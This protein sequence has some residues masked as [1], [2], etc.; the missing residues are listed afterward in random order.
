MSLTFLVPNRCSWYA[1]YHPLGVPWLTS[2][3]QHGRLDRPKACPIRFTDSRCLGSLRNASTDCF[4]WDLLSAPLP[5]IALAGQPPWRFFR[6][7]P[8]GLVESALGRFALDD[9]LTMTE[10][11][12]GGNWIVAGFYR[13]LAVA[14]ENW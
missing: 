7:E 5:L 11:C 3:L 14:L 1:F 12:L 8:L 6:G 4:V 9:A 2:A 13:V 10:S